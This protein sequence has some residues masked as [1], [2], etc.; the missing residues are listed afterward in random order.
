MS[1]FVFV[2]VIFWVLLHCINVPYTS[3]AVWNTHNTSLSSKSNSWLIE[4]CFFL[5][6]KISTTLTFDTDWHINAIQPIK[7]HRN[8]Q[9]FMSMQTRIDRSI[10]E[11][12]QVPE[13]KLMLLLLSMR[14]QRAPVY[15][16]KWWYYVIGICNKS[17]N[18][19]AVVCTVEVMTAN[20]EDDAK[21]CIFTFL[22]CWKGSFCANHGCCLML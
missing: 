21:P 18:F 13:N 22:L 4:L 19:M 7:V 10:L 11:A 20:R 12:F 2:F 14:S 15:R 1:I 6:N 16:P 3:E 8:C 5:S 17:H 9:P